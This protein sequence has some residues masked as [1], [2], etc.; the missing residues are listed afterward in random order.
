MKKIYE[1]PELTKIL[2]SASDIVTVSLGEDETEF[3]EEN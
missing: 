3:F 2:F 1:V